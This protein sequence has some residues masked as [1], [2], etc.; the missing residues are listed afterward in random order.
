MAEPIQ[1]QVEFT[2]AQ[3]AA[4]AADTVST[5]LDTMSDRTNAAA[6]SAQELASRQTAAATA[7]IAFGQRLAAA[8]NAI[9]GVTSALGVEGQAA[10]LIGKITQTSAAMA[11]LGATFGPQG[12]LVGG[13]LG[14]AIPAVQGLIQSFRE[15]EE[16][17]QQLLISTGVLVESYDTILQRIQAVS[18]ARSRES[19]LAMGLG[20]TQ[21]QEAA[22]TRAQQ[23]A[24]AATQTVARAQ[25]ALNQASFDQMQ[26]AITG[27]RAAEAA[28]R[29]TRSELQQAQ[30]AQRLAIAD[31]QADAERLM[32]ELLSSG[33]TATAARRGGGARRQSAEEFR[34]P[35]GP[36]E[37]ERMY[38]E[39][40]AEENAALESQ[41]DLT[42]YL[43]GLR[44]EA[45]QQ[46]EQAADRAD[47]L[48]DR[49]KER[50]Q[51][52]R[53]QLIESS[54]K[55][56]EV[57]D[58]QR[59]GYREVTGVIVGGLNDA[60]QSIISGQKTAGE[61]F[62]GLLASFLKYISEQSMLKAIF[63]YAEAIASFASYKYDQGVQHLAAGV[64]YTAVAVAA[65]A[66]AVALA[67]PSGGA[68]GDQKPASPEAGA[69]GEGGRG[70]DVVI[71]WNSPV[72][73]AGT[74]AE[75]GRD[76]ASMI[77][78]GSQRFGT[79]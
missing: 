54:E 8:S 7:A 19:R 44:E 41:A 24:E 11:Q 25:E 16:A 32:E 23:A 2:G 22:V 38:A 26:N 45:I 55:Q 77:R 57:A 69:A 66:G 76:M 29:R 51:E 42:R 31:A 47:M 61:A 53:D 73:T 65:G 15:Q 36:S 6:R 56:R 50:Q 59:Q 79:V 5:R 18:S 1:I 28:E 63:E 4:R 72:V 27:L 35:S 30:E 49:E 68:Q 60:L 37:A 78:A 62:E 46:Q 74:R 10:G 34:A 14:A 33:Q 17:Q 20:T 58:Q 52:I 70:G 21:E 3:E 43:M 12:A 13:I 75:L 48:A 67:Q 40:L 39:M 9:Q 64:A 71:N